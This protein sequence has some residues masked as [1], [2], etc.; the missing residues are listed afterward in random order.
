MRRWTSLESLL[1]VDVNGNGFFMV[2]R[3][4]SACGGSKT[5]PKCPGRPPET[6]VKRGT[7]GIRAPPATGCEKE[8]GGRQG[9]A[10]LC[11]CSTG[12]R[13]EGI[14]E[15][16]ARRESKSARSGP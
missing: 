7:P 12:S 5:T 8:T 2:D 16:D 10:R 15:A 11:D 9:E 1:L 13:D 14:D 4:A 3:V 6:G